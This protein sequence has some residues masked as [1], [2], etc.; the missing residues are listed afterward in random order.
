[1][2]VSGAGATQ[3]DD[4]RGPNNFQ[5]VLKFVGGRPHHQ[6]LAV[7]ILVE[8]DLQ[9]SDYLDS[10][11]ENIRQDPRLPIWHWPGRI[12]TIVEDASISSIRRWHAGERR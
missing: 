1:M 6:A 12:S 4:F 8:H 5:G 7:E 10:A 11:V 3:I 2:R 9:V